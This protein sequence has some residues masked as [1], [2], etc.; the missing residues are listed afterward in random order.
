VIRKKDSKSFRERGGMEKRRRERVSATTRWIN[1]KR[2]KRNRQRGRY[3]HKIYVYMYIERE[4]EKERERERREGNKEIE[5][6]R[7]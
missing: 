6:G 1:R 2:G 4:A 5:G 3:L 7:L